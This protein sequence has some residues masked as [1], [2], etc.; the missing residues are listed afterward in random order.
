MSV[1]NIAVLILE[2]ITLLVMGWITI[3]NIGICPLLE[4]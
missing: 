1:R 4:C 2:M 3:T